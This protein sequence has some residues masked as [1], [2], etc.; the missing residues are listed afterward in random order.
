[1]FHD[2]SRKQAYYQLMGK[3]SSDA[4]N[5]TP[6]Y[7]HHLLRKWDGLGR[8]RRVYTQNIDRLEEKVGLS[9]DHTYSSGPHQPSSRARCIPLHGDLSTLRCTTNSHIFPSVDYTQSMMNGEIPE[10]PQ[11]N[12]DAQDRLAHGKR[13]RGRTS[14]LR[15][16]VILY[17]EVHPDEESLGKFIED[18]L[19]EISRCRNPCILLVVGTSLQIPGTK[20]LVRDVSSMLK[21]GNMSTSLSSGQPIQTICVNLDFPTPNQRWVGV[22]DTWVCGDLQEFASMV[23]EDMG[24]DVSTY[25][26]IDINIVN[27]V[28]HK[29][30]HKTMIVI[31]TMSR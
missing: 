10:C 4:H 20:K 7:F 16:N 18:D 11:C 12:T 13:A 3:L 27:K 14:E 23:L 6:T 2:P 5:A 28:A 17:D 31:F 29:T 26:H 24:E 8:L 22:F 19:R 25:K 21:Q 9:F 15:P 30:F 1:M